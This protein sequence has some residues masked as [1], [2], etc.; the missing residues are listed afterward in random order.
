[1]GIIVVFLS[2]NIL[3]IAVSAQ[4]AIRFIRISFAYCSLV[5]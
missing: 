1:M 4:V 3:L 2:N 5:M